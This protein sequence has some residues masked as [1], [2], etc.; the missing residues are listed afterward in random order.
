MTSTMMRDAVIS[1]PMLGDLHMN[2]PA[3]FP[4]FGREIY[5][6]GVILA[7]AFLAVLV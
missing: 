3:S 2:P 4:L 1:F 6:Y 5:W 7:L